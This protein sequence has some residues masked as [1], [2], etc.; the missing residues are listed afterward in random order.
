MDATNATFVRYARKAK[1]WT[2]AELA[3][4]LGLSQGYVSLLEGGH[5]EVPARL[6]TRL[7]TLLVLAPTDLPLPKD[8]E[9]LSGNAV[10][11]ALGRLGYPG[12]GHLRAR[13][14]MNP[15]NLVL[16]ALLSPE[17]DARLAEALPWVLA[18]HPDLD[19]SWLVS[20]AKQ[21]DLQNRLGFLVGLARTT[22]E[23]DGRSSAAAL[24]GKW[25]RVLE[26]S[27]LDRD[28]PVSAVPMTEAERRW[29]RANRLLEAARWRVLS[30]LRPAKPL[31]AAD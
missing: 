23:T 7:A 13:R 27:R 26:R 31:N 20:R 5:R 18:K 17:L 22:S 9:P 30:Q 24:L 6:R 1:G 15:A 12:F 11:A 21:H 2:Q 3:N 28:D 4:R 10:A 19:W 8:V 29:L 14:P 16:G 25:E